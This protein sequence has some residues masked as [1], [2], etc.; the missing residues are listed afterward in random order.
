MFSIK[1]E[2]SP[3]LDL[4]MKENILLNCKARSREEVIREAGEMLYKS[5]YVKE[6][7]IDGMRKRELSFS[8]HVGNGIAMPHGVEEV[9]HDIITSGIVIMIF[10]EGTNWGEDIVNVVIG[11]AGVG[12]EHLSILANVAGR[13]STPEEVARLIN[14]SVEEVYEVL[15]GEE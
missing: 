12:E 5:G 10:P 9:K 2:Q 1:K 11:I 3:K 6:G 13:L 4:L 7:Y 14:G 15:T 8:T